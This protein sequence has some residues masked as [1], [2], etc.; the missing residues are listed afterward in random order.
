MIDIKIIDENCPICHSFKKIDSSL[1]FNL[2]EVPFDQISENDPFYEHMEIKFSEQ[3]V[4]LPLYIF[5]MLDGKFFSFTPENQ[6]Q[7][8]KN[9]KT[10]SNIRQEVNR[11]GQAT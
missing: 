2:I 4:H 6:A 9:A 1:F 8:K 5:E 11:Y 3:M 7:L 10:I